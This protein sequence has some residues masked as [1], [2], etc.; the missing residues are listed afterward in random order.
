[1]RQQLAAL[2]VQKPGVAAKRVRPADTFTR[3]FEAAPEDETAC[4]DPILQSP[5]HQA[6]P[7]TWRGFLHRCYSLFIQSGTAPAA[8][9]YSHAA[10]DHDAL[11]AGQLLSRGQLPFEGKEDSPLLSRSGCTGCA[12][13]SGGSGSGRMTAAAAAVISS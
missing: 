10:G 3:Q 11:E 6:P 4:A 9:G 7:P 1:M 5:A 12:N 8:T 2:Q 13:R